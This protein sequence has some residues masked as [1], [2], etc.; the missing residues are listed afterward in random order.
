MSLLVCWIHYTLPLPY[1]K[2][3]FSFVEHCE[4]QYRFLLQ[5]LRGNDSS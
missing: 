1:K 5:D 3:L 4:I 2:E